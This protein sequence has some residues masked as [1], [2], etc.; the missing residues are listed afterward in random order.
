MGPDELMVLGALL[1]A[2]PTAAW[3]LG[4][5]N[6]TTVTVMQLAV[7]RVARDE[8]AIDELRTEIATADAEVEAILSELHDMEKAE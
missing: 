8:K 2:L 1:V 3:L 6:W 5:R 4:A 7:T